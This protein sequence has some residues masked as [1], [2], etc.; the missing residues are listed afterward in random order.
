MAQL[1][2]LVGNR[3]SC[4]RSLQAWLAMRHAGLRFDVD[5]FSGTQ[6]AISLGMSFAAEP[7]VLLVDNVPIWGVL[8]IGEF[9]A[10]HVPSL[11]PRDPRARALARSVAAEGLEGLSAIRALLPFDVTQRFT[12]PRLNLAVQHDLSRLA[13]LWEACRRE[14]GAGGPYL[15]GKFSLAD[16]VHAGAAMRLIGNSIRLQGEAASYL[17]TLATL[18]VLGEWIEEASGNRRTAEPERSDWANAGNRPSSPAAPAQD[19]MP[20]TETVA[21]RETR[22][23][24]G[25]DGGVKPIGAGIHRRH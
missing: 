8:P 22:D 1:T 18:P 7:P 14:F 25:Y 15:F 11:W 4:D 21:R 17:Q 13:A 19:R 2:L 12:I 10:E 20:P 23:I 16:A 24:E 9:L 6:R 5:L 3:A